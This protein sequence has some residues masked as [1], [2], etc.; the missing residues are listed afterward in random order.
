MK[1]WAPDLRWWV[2]SSVC[3]CLGRSSYTGGSVGCCFVYCVQN[4]HFS[5]SSKK[6]AVSTQVLPSNWTCQKPCLLIQPEPVAYHCNASSQCRQPP[7]WAN[8][9]PWPLGSVISWC[10]RCL[11]FMVKLTDMFNSEQF[12]W[13]KWIY[14]SNLRGTTCT[15]FSLLILVNT[16]A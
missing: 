11:Y 6:I 5:P 16:L 2:D 7:P 3:C 1:I 15:V 4:W 9:E 13:Q 10:R 14:C 12:N 8:S